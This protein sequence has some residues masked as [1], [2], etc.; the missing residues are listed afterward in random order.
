MHLLRTGDGDPDLATVYAVPDRSR[1]HLRVNFVTSLDG[2]VEA[3]GVSR[4]IS[5]DADRRVFGFLRA[6]ADAVLVGA[7]T[8]RKEGYGPARVRSELAPRRRAAGAVGGH[9]TLVIVSAA[10]DRN[11][12]P[13]SFWTAFVS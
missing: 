5:S 8:L 11:A 9:P 6:H 4:G 3:G 13:A 2:A 1:P 12:C 7:G 10:L